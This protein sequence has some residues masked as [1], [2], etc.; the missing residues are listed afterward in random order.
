MLVI[1]IKWPEKTSLASFCWPIYF[2]V[3]SGVVLSPD[4]E[5]RTPEVWKCSVYPIGANNDLNNAPSPL[6]SSTRT[7]H[8]NSNRFWRACSTQN[9]ETVHTKIDYIWK[10]DTYPIETQIHPKSPSVLFLSFKL[11][12]RVVWP[13][14]SK[15]RI[16]DVQKWPYIPLRYK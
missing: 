14:N 7:G 3:D 16:V 1:L 11:L 2:M 10:W 8:A 5:N 9:S 4:S 12:M 15:N 6:T 13:P